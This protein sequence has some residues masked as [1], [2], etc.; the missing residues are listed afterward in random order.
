MDVPPPKILQRTLRKITE[1]L[2]RALAD[3]SQPTPDWSDFEWIAARAVAAMHGVSS[4]LSIALPWNGP[5]GWT[6]FLSDQRHHTAM[7]HARIEGLLKELDTQAIRGG[8]PVLALKGAA[9]HAMG[10][11]AAGERPMADIDILVRPN[12]AGKMATAL[13]SLGYRESGEDSEERVFK[14]L[15][16][17][18]PGRFGEHSDNDLKVELHDRICERLPWRVVDTTAEI[19]PSQ[20]HSGLNAYPSNASLMIHLLLHAAGAMPSKILRLVQLHDIALLSARMTEADWNPLLETAAAGRLWWAF[21]PL[22][23][24][25][26][27][28]AGKI[29]V[30]VLDALRRQCPQLLRRKA[31]HRTLFEVSLSYLWVTAFPGIEWSQSFSEAIEY[32]MSRL[33]PN[34]DILAARERIVETQMWAHQGEWAA[35]SQSRRILRWIASRPTRPVTM[36]AVSAA[37][38][39][40]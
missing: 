31:E 24:T 17:H 12:D 3:P 7:R 39:F 38:A 25:S 13:G 10:L 23:L 27:Y 36:H 28:Y 33:R 5:D 9:L 11:Y 16:G 26:R 8:V 6:R 37:L 30:R 32:A 35:L 40:A 15:N 4:L 29:P 22:K 19:F 34:S 14:P 21:P 18:A 1:S 2:A 20:P